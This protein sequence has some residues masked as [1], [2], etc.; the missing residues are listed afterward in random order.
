MCRPAVA[1]AVMASTSGSWVELR[2]ASAR[3]SRR[4]QDSPVQQQGWGAANDQEEEEEHDHL[5]DASPMLANSAGRSSVMPLTTKKNGTKAPKAIAVSFGQDMSVAGAQRLASDDPSRE[6]A[7]EQVEPEVVGRARPARRSAR[8]SS[9]PRAATA[10]QRPLE[11]RHRPGRRAPAATATTTA[12][13]TKAS[14]ISALC[15]VPGR[16][17][18]ASAPGSDRTRRPR[19][20]PGGNCQSACDLAAVGQDRDQGPD[21]RRVSAEPVYS[22]ESTTPRR[23][24]RRPACR[25]SPVTG[26]SRASPAAA[27]GRGSS[28]ARSRIRRRRTAAPA[29]DPRE[30]DELVRVGRSRAGRSPPTE[31]DTTTGMTIPWPLISAARCP[32][33]PRRRS[34]PR[35]GPVPTVV[36]RDRFWR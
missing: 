22:A 2:N 34:P 10:L 13:A 36:G 8:G 28:R 6:A 24:A 11:Q 30:R 17:G 23:G 29:R 33:P 4:G 3:R 1:K 20:R 25:R 9:G 7:E 35:N 18:R 14:R 5:A 32:P 12:T 19:R 15:S 26:P 27:G 16:R 31:L 21:R